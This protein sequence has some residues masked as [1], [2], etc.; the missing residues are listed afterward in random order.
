VSTLNAWDTAGMLF[1]L[2]VTTAAV[3]EVVLVLLAVIAPPC[4]AS[5]G[6]HVLS[7]YCIHALFKALFIYLFLWD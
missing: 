1:V 2:I 4:W 7:T 6:E 5:S 3:M